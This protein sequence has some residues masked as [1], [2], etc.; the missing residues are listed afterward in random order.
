[1]KLKD[2]TLA[3][4]NAFTSST[5]IYNRGDEYARNGNV[6][7][8]TYFSKSDTLIA[9]VTGNYGDYQVEITIKRGELDADCSCPYDGYPCKHAVAVLLQFIR[10]R[11]E[12]LT[13]AKRE[14]ATVSSLE[15]QL[16]ATS[17]DF[18][19]K[20]ILDGINASHEFRRHV[21]TTF[22]AESNDMMKLFRSQIKEAFP[23]IEFDEYNIPEIAR[24]LRSILKSVEASPA[25]L[26]LEVYWAVIDRT[27]KELNAY[28]I[29]DM[30]LE[31]VAIVGMQTMTEIF[32][33]M[34][35]KSKSLLKKVIQGLQAHL[36]VGNNGINDSIAA[37]IDELERL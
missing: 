2:I 27:L 13:A 24:E 20:T 23:S 10:N 3:D 5:T 28:G 18:L 30:K 17:K 11:K 16:L 4:V 9:D 36:D 7:D 21:L 19:V 26:K 6:Q 35:A 31:D 34:P 32:Q 12:Y 15:K 25:Q 1:M 33:Q 8:L 29:D 37:T 14:V 22:E